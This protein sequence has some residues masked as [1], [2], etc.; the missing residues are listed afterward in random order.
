MFVIVIYSVGSIVDTF[1]RVPDIG[2][3]HNTKILFLMIAYVFVHNNTFAEITLMIH[4]CT[5]RLFA[6]EAASTQ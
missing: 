6:S 3:Y 2:K 5:R 4:S 1:S